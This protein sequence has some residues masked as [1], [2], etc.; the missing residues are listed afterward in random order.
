KNAYLGLSNFQNCHLKYVNFQGADLESTNLAGTNLAQANL[1]NASLRQTNLRGANLQGANLENVCLSG[2]IYDGTTKF[3][4]SF[5]PEK[6]GMVRLSSS[7][8]H[9]ET[10]QNSGA[11]K[12]IWSWCRFSALNL[13]S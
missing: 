7:L 13:Q 11:I 10:E 1:K 5:S 8:S 4:L 12:K 9:T 6:A 2:A 3:D